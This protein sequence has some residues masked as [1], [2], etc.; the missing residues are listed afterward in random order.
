M[1]QNEQNLSFSIRS[2][3][4]SVSALFFLHYSTYFQS[5]IDKKR[6]E[7]K[8]RK[9]FAKKVLYVSTISY[10]VIDVTLTEWKVRFAF[11]RVDEA[12]NCSRKF[13]PCS[14]NNV[15]IHTRVL[16]RCFSLSLSLT[17]PEKKNQRNFYSRT[18]LHDVDLTSG[19]SYLSRQLHFVSSEIQGNSR[20]GC[21]IHD[22]CERSLAIRTEERK[23]KKEKKIWFC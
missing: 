2:I 21:I 23:K 20:S 15:N 22:L 19:R 6:K 13:R 9:H 8:Q 7:K 16:Q 5:E 10:I 18:Y 17:A 3:S 12:W 11:G 14:Y 4:C 1:L